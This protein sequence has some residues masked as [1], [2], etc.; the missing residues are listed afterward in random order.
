MTKAIVFDCFGVLTTEG[1]IAFRNQYFANQPQKLDKANQLLHR[2]DRGRYSYDI[3]IDDIAQLSGVPSQEVRARLDDNVPN[4]PLL[5][6]IGNH[7][8]G[9]YKIGMLSNAG[10]NWLETIFETAQLKMFDEIALSYET[11]HLKPHPEAY[12]QIAERLGALPSEVILLDDQPRHCEGAKAAGM[13]AILYRDFSQAKADLE[14]LLA[15]P[16]A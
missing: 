14:K 1:W 16:E 2:L 8:K 3:F 15:N 11:G 7:L 5:E 13:K 9:K 12:H 6:Y 4:R 10:D